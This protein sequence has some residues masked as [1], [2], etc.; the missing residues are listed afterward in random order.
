MSGIPQ[1]CGRIEINHDIRNPTKPLLAL[2]NAMLDHRQFRR[3]ILREF[4]GP[5]DEFGRTTIP[6]DGQNVV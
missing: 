1:R 2:A 4:G 3:G 6:G 5:L